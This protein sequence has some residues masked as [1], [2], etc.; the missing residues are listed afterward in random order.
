MIY[1][2]CYRRRATPNAAGI[3]EVAGRAFYGRNRLY[4]IL[5]FPLHGHYALFKHAMLD[6]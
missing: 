4:R 2:T 1:M 3:A 6:E 5:Q